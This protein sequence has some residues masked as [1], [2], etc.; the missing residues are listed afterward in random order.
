MFKTKT[1]FIIINY[2]MFALVLGVFALPL[3][4]DAGRPAIPQGV[5]PPSG[6]K[7]YVVRADSMALHSC[8]D[9]NCPIIGQAQRGERMAILETVGH[10]YRVRGFTSGREGWLNTKP[11]RPMYAKAVVTARALH[12]RTCPTLSCAIIRTL[13]KGQ[14]LVVQEVQGR[15]TRVRLDFTEISGWVYNKYIRYY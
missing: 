7:V 10:W 4:A 1:I 8:G 11:G 14:Q 6:P 5:M 12:L 2:L 9:S 15:W 13:P 3:P